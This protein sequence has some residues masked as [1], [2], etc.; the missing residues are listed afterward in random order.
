L[1]GIVRLCRDESSGHTASSKKKRQLVR[2]TASTKRVRWSGAS[3][4]EAV[5]VKD[6]RGLRA[7]SLVLPA[8]VFLASCYLSLGTEC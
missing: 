4:Q 2:L 8:L 1:R 5:I 7:R 3:D 6:C